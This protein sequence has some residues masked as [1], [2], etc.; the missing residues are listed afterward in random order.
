ML[1]SFL[2]G[3]HP[4]DSKKYTFDKAIESPSLPDE[5]VIPVS[6]HIGAPCTPIVKVGDSVKKGQ[7]IANSDAFMQSPIHASISGKV[8]KIADMPHA[9]KGSCLSIVIKNDGLDE[10]IEGIPLN[11]EWDKLNA[12][13][14][15]NIIK[16]A[17]IVGMG[18]ATFP[19][20]IKLNP[21]KDKKIDVCIVN[22]A[23]CEPYLT[24]D[25]RMMLEY[26]DRIVTGVKIIMKVLGVTKVFIGIEDNKM[27]AVKV[28][29]DAFK[30]TSVEVVPLPTKYPQGAEKMLIKVLTGREVP[31]GGLP[32][33]VG[34]V[35]QNIGTTVAISDAVVNGIPLIQR[36]T[37]V[38]G[39]AIKEPKNLLLRIGTSFKY[40]INYCGGFSKDP[41]K[42]IMGGPM[43]GF[44]QSTLDVPVI[45]GVSGILA[46][47]SDVVNS[48]E[49]SPCIRCG[50]CVKA[51][52]MGLIPSMLSILGQRHK[53]KEAKEDYN[54]F[55]C[56]ECGSCV[57]SC[58]AKRNIVQYIKYSKA[59]NLA[60][61]ANK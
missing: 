57:Y 34:V 5:V 50:R 61:A 7:V 3:I 27:D 38:S 4:N 58:P 15:R 32:M 16:D 44:A 8:T 37:T 18:G 39:D 31:T 43:M 49:E 20:H 47:S 45:K 1:K 33:D 35:V 42:I 9:S 51:C 60:H 6:Q 56:I 29:K 24:A 26:A 23:E 53:Y 30:D 17:G 25:Y 52:P 46:L 10:W 11:R 21:S 28:M 41:E 19:T 12:E 2:G 48:G 14:I 22:A 59:Q 36:I 40:A 55:N 54:L 13:E